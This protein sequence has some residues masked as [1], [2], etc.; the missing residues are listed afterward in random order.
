MDINTEKLE[1][2]GLTTASSKIK[3]LR[4]LKQKMT[5]AYEHYRYVT[6][7]KI[8][9][10]NEKLKK[11]TLKEDER[12]LRY[13]HLAFTPL[14]KYEAVPPTAVLDKIEEAI[15]KRCFDS[16]EI[17][18]IED[19]VEVKDPIVF[20]RIKGCPDRFYV[21]QWDDDVKIEDILKENEG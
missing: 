7:D 11:E 20:G 3:E 19:K 13:K 10:F 16:F 12:A 4:E 2:L 5:I 1:K 21:G 17:A 6:P 18:K 8:D 14:D 15:G 9:A